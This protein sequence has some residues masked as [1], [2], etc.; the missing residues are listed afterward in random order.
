MNNLCEHEVTPS[1]AIVRSLDLSILANPSEEDHPSTTFVYL[2]DI[3]KESGWVQVPLLAEGVAVR[4]FSVVP[5]GQNEKDGESSFSPSSPDAGHLLVQSGYYH[6]CVKGRESG[7]DKWRVEV[8]A[9]TPFSSQRKNALS[10][11]VVP[12][13]MTSL[14][15]EVAQASKE[16][17]LLMK[18]EPSLSTEEYIITPEEGDEESLTKAEVIARFVFFSLKIISK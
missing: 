18:V 16:D 9:T 6:L 12:S 1:N 15:A 2:V 11:G 7:V 8:R 13:V 5:E 14:R 3:L 17:E 4:D 10:L